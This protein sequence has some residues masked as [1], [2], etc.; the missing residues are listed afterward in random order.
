MI[1]CVQSEGTF[2]CRAPWIAESFL[3][4]ICTYRDP[5]S[6]TL[7]YTLSRRS[8]RPD[9][10]IIFQYWFIIT[11]KIYW[12]AKQFF[13]NSLKLCPK[14]NLSFW[15]GQKTYW[16]LPKWWNFAKSSHTHIF[17]NLK[18]VVLTVRAREFRL[19]HDNRRIRRPTKSAAVEDEAA[20]DNVV[21][22]VNKVVVV[23]PLFECSIS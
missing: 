4:L 5:L 23:G 11:I 3:T 8:V 1:R 10:Y 20:A 19:R 14:T 13:R 21:F 6:V 17:V 18:K 2:C 15:K 7:T 22:Q 12:K 16:T 9:G